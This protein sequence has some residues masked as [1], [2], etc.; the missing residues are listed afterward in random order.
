MHSPCLVSWIDSGLSIQNL[1]FDYWKELD[2]EMTCCLLLQPDAQSVLET[3]VEIQRLESKTTTLDA[4]LD[5]IPSLQA[6][7]GSKVII[8]VKDAR[9]YVDLVNTNDHLSN[10]HQSLC[11]SGHYF[12]KYMEWLWTILYKLLKNMSHYY[13]RYDLIRQ[14]LLYSIHDSEV[15]A[16]AKLQISLLFLSSG[17]SK[18]DTISFTRMM[19]QYLCQSLHSDLLQDA[20][21][22][23]IQHLL[24]LNETEWIKLFS[25]DWLSMI[26]GFGG[27]RVGFLN[28]VML[29]WQKC[30]CSDAE[31]LAFSKALCARM[32]EPLYG[33]Q[34]L[35]LSHSPCPLMVDW[36]TQALRQVLEGQIVPY[37]LCDFLNVCRYYVKDQTAVSIIQKW[38]QSF[39]DIRLDVLSGL[40]CVY[41][42]H[43]VKVFL[44]EQAHLV[45]GHFQNWMVGQSPSLP[46][47]TTGRLQHQLVPVG[48]PSQ[49]QI[50]PNL[51]QSMYQLQSNSTQ[52]QRQHQPNLSQSQGQSLA[53]AHPE[54]IYKACFYLS[55]ERFNQILHYGMMPHQ[56]KFVLSNIG[57]YIEKNAISK[58]MLAS[59]YQARYIMINTV[60]KRVVSKT[61]KLGRQ[62]YVATFKTSHK[63]ALVC[64]GLCHPINM[65]MNTP[66]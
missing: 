20:C 52:S 33:F 40:V 29:V 7:L 37:C 57:F 38:F 14:S 13:G 36:W 31:I 11:L 10:G 43:D 35:L 47:T 62:W 50:Q 16:T 61:Q 26:K 48:G 18:L 51:S 41:Y 21:L 15:T 45:F 2:S 64:K 34:Q 60:L 59:I 1:P 42:E 24:S 63:N 25:N 55:A 65:E 32:A 30:P 9:L 8:H 4:L 5:L 27:F 17:C 58:D 3:L 49:H 12:S 6:Y 19:L 22:P 46:L 39:H 66:F 23:I 44:N 28:A 53:V 56:T 54:L